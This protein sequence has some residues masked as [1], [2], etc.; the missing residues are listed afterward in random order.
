M[1]PCLPPPSR[2]CIHGA[3]RAAYHSSPVPSI[4]SGLARS[5]RIRA[6]AFPLRPRRLCGEC[7][8]LYVIFP[9]E[10]TVADGEETAVAVAAVRVAAGRRIR[11]RARPFLHAV[12]PR[13]GRRGIRFCLCILCAL[14][15]L[16]G[17]CLLP[18]AVIPSESRCF[19][20]GRRGI[21]FCLCVL[22]ALR[23]LCGKCLYL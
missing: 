22:C 16:C 14:C 9:S 17:E 4:A 23:V 8:S 10:S 21:C 13:S 6:F 1:A 5:G 12:I 20:P 7:V 15:A 11:D 18:Y 2:P 19:L 3:R